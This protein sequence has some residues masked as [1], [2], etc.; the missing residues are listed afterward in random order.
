MK[1]KTPTTL[2]FA[3]LGLLHQSPM[4]GYDLR[5]V[6]EETA[7]GN[8]SSSPGAIY[9]ALNRLEQQGLVRATEDRTKNMRPKRLYTP[10]ERGREVF[11]Q[12]L[13]RDVSA[14]EA[15]RNIEELM[16]RF[17]FHWVLD[18]AADTRRLLEGL[19]SHL[20][21]YVAELEA[22]RALFPDDAPIH[23]RLALQA[24]IEQ[25]RAFLRWARQALQH[26]EGE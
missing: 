8:Y 22:Q 5:K 20:Q 1:R 10:S 3:L 26:F 25:S 23:S 18:S 14:D 13:R 9:P 11:R 2:G 7:L 16:L 4:S 12:W 15:G 6:F 21:R 17:A 24:G 19:L